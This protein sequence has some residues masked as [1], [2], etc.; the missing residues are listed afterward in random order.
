MLAKRRLR[1]NHYKHSRKRKSELV[2]NRLVLSL[3]ALAFLAVTT[4]VSLLFILAHDA[5]TQSRYFD[6]EAITVEGN[7]RVTVENIV[8]IG[9]VGIGDN[10]LAMNLK[11]LRRKILGN[12]WIAEVSVERDLPDTI[13][14][15]VREY[16]PAAIVRFDRD[17]FV[18][19]TGE[20]IK[21]VDDSENIDVPILTGLTLADFAPDSSDRSPGSS[22]FLQVVELSQLHGSVLPLHDIERID[23]D[24]HIGVTL[25]VFENGIAIKL[26]REGYTQKFNRIRDMIAYLRQGK[27]LEHVACI[28]LNDLNR[29][30]VG[31]IGKRPLLGV[32]HRKET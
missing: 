32:C 17:Y 9:Q 30:V 15:F 24:P 3:K 27:H 31:A 25:S 18:S 8:Q 7:T 2:F 12:P 22:A 26:G 11:L 10:I 20:I 6:A 21:P 5:L 1:K 19:T 23:I 14:I 28:D 16:T 29:V 4:G 13:R